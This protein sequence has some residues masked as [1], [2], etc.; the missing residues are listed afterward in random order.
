MHHYDVD[1][2]SRS[3]E[4]ESPR[5]TA[6]SCN[7]PLYCAEDLVQSQCAALRSQVGQRPISVQ[8]VED[9]F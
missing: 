9:V 8:P 7:L 6:V 5:L 4:R 3:L 2:E 1:A